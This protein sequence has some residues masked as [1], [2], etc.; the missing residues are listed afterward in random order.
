MYKRGYFSFR[1]TKE[2][3]IFEDKVSKKRIILKGGRL[4]SPRLEMIYRF[5]FNDILI[6]QLHFC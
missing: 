1:R 5:F 2:D 4:V 3:R 6:H